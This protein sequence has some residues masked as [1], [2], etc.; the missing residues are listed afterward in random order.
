MEESIHLCGIP[1]VFVPIDDDANAVN[2][3]T[4]FRQF[5]YLVFEF[6]AI[7]FGEQLGNFC[8]DRDRIFGESFLIQQM[9]AP[10]QSLGLQFRIRIRHL[11]AYLFEYQVERVFS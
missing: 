8:N 1:V 11:V 9:I 2:L 7:G 3:L 10:L 6:L 5:A 4:V